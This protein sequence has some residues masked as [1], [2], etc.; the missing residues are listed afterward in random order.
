MGAERWG[1]KDALDVTER[2]A[3]IKMNQAAGGIAR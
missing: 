2:A 3:E 1:Q